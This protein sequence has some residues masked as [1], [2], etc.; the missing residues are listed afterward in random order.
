M[1]VSKWAGSVW[2][3][4][5]R[6]LPNTSKARIVETYKEPLSDA[7]NRYH[8]RL[9]DA[10][11]SSKRHIITRLRRYLPDLSWASAESIVD[12]AIDEGASLIRVLNSKVSTSPP[13]K[14]VS[15]CE[16]YF[17]CFHRS[18]FAA[19]SGRYYC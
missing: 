13:V 1:D 2:K 8:V 10:S 17:A 11:V 5:K 6:F 15:V 14:A 3:G 4:I 9:V 16:K 19:Y 7:G 18:G 12:A